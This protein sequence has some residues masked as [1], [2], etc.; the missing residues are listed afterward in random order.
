M[1]QF[2]HPQLTYATSSVL[3]VLVL[4]GGLIAYKA[5]ASLE[6]LQS[7]ARTGAFHSHHPLVLG[8]FT[9]ATGLLTRSAS[10]LAIIWPALLFGI[11]IS[12]AVRTLVSPRWLAERFG[13]G[14]S[15][16]AHVAAGTAGVPLMLCSCCV[17][18]I[19][20]TVYE[21]C[22][23]LGHSL[24]VMLAAPSLNPA[25]LALTFMF[26][27]PRVAWARL[28]L[29]LAAVFVGT[30]FTTRIVEPSLVGSTPRPGA[31]ADEGDFLVAAFLRSCLHVTA[32]TLPLIVVGI[33]AAMA[34]ADFVPLATVGSPLA[35][36][37]AVA[38]AAF[39]AVPIALP[40]FFEVPLALTLLGAGAPAGAAVAVLFAGP[41]VNLPSLLTIAHAT[42]WKVSVTVAAMIWTLAVIGGL[43]AG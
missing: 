30:A 20:T 29:A 31:V 43:L 1:R 39:I 14:G 19:F 38:L 25:A 10:Y 23:R 41:A 17:A 24:G 21:R 32:R 26:F 7:A 28:M 6:V 33:V 16:C 40:T 34:I 8:E 5:A 35:T 9:G 11:L 15:F 18:P 36:G 27:A 37:L 3:V 12:G 22:R 42:S 4:V 13:H 2:A